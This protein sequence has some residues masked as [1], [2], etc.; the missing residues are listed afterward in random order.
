MKRI[1][2]MI[3]FSLLVVSVA[4]VADDNPFV[5]TWKGNLAKSKYSPGP[6]PKYASTVTMVPF[7]SDGL[8]VTVEGATAKGEKTLI[9][10]SAKFDGKESPL[11]QTG[12]GAVAGQTVTLKRIDTNTVERIAYL[13]GKMLVKEIWV[14]SKDGKTRTS[15]QTGTNAQGETVNNV[16]V[17]ERQ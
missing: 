12:P 4:A 15:T 10:Y 5:G 11:T 3:A 13:K 8:K 17:S 14:V 7:G 6:A 9:T 2:M 16:V 1:L